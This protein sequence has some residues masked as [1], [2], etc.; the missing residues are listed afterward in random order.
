MFPANLMCFAISDTGE[1]LSEQS[2]Q[3]P[4]NRNANLSR[5]GWHFHK[6]NGAPEKPGD[7]SGEF[8]A[9]YFGNAV[10]LAN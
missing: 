8:H 4:V 3:E 5:Q 2:I 6:V 7:H 1:I 10:A 9:V